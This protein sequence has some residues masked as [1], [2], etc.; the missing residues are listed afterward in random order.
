M[1][2]HYFRLM[3]HASGYVFNI[4]NKDKRMGV[5][6]NNVNII[7]GFKFFGNDTNVG[8]CNCEEKAVKHAVI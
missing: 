4:K 5:W 8:F 3:K 6:K 2:Q 7:I 1:E